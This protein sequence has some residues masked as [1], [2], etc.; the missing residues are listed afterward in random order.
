MDEPDVNGDTPLDAAVEMD[1]V[2]LVQ[3][4]ID[5]K[6]ASLNRV[7]RDHNTPFHG[8]ISP[9]MITILLDRGAELQGFHYAHGVH[10]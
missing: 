2:D 1:F 6:G 9:A 4:L 5:E 3:W 7:G 8:A 10:D